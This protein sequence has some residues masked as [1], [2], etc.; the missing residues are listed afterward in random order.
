VYTKGAWWRNVIAGAA[1]FEPPLGACLDALRD[2]S[3]SIGRPLVGQEEDK[4]HGD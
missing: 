3:T 1:V 4:D 2:E